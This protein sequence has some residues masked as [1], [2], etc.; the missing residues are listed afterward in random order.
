MRVRLRP[1]VFGIDYPA[2][3]NS[4]KIG[5][6]WL[7]SRER[8][9]LDIMTASSA[10]PLAVPLGAATSALLAYELGESPYI[11]QQR[12][13]SHPELLLSMPKLKTLSGPVTNGMSAHGFDHER[14]GPIGKRVR[15]LHLDEL[16]QLYSVLQGKMSIIGPRPQTPIAFEQTMDLLNSAEQKEFLSARRD[17]RP[18]MIWPGGEQ[19]HTLKK[20]MGLYE[21]AHTI[22]EYVATASMENDIRLITISFAAVIR[23]YRDELTGR[24]ADE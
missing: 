16:P 24:T 18:G 6:E 14:A 17:A 12:V 22:I 15:Q 20:D 3:N 2:M 4:R 7:A 19:Q 1:H 5:P 10:L 23:S 8:R 11:V 21:K 13:G 9:G